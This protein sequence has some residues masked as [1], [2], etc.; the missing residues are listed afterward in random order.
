MIIWEIMC[1]TR[2]GVAGM[3][4]RL[5]YR[6]KRLPP[7]RRPPPDRRRRRRILFVK[8]L[9]VFALIVSI[10]VYIES[11]LGPIVRQ[12]ALARVAYIAGKAMN[13]AINEQIEKDV[14]Q[15]ED[16]IQFHKTTDG[17]I[18]AYTPNYG[19]INL[20]KASI[21]GT[22]MEKIN[23]L[24]TSQLNIPLGNI[25]NGEVLSGLGPKI[26]IRILP[27]GTAEARFA[28][29]FSSAGI[30]QTRHQIIVEVTVDISVVL[31]GMQTGTQ[32]TSQ[33]NVAETVIVGNVPNTYT[34]L[35]ESGRTPM[36]IYGDFDLD[37]NGD[38]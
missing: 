35:E 37:G 2:E 38:N 32:V 1:E 4:R 29:A 30:N 14:E 21:I 12:M 31:P 16:L 6:P 13:D 17:V 10:L 36:E 7:R 18:T 19:K 27:V 3:A 9:V 28:T 26:P 22:V 33:V 5:L 11:R 25:I 8:L 20:L 24:D 15:F 34:Y 23:N